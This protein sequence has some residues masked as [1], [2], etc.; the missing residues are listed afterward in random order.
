MS[1]MTPELSIATTAANESQMIAFAQS[2]IRTPGLSG[3]EE[4]VARLVAQ[5]MKSL[6]YQNVG[7][8]EVGNASGVI[9]GGDGPTIMLNGHIDT[10][11]PG[12]ASGWKYPAYGGDLVDDHLWGRGSV[13]MKGPIAAMI[14]GIANF[15]HNDHRAAGRHT[16]H[17]NRQ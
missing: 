10:V 11:D 1:K 6:G 15:P 9:K 14:Y 3:D 16:C 4:A 7:F 13:D 2:L 12:P 8:D 17:H 5:E